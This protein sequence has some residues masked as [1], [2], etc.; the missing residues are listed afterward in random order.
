MNYRVDRT[1][2]HTKW[3]RELLTELCE[4]MEHGPPGDASFKK[5]LKGVYRYAMFLSFRC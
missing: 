3:V 4:E 5:V 2:T 1:H